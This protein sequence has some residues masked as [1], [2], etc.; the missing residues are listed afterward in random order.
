MLLQHRELCGKHCQMCFLSAL[1]WLPL[2]P[3]DLGIHFKSR[4]CSTLGMFANCSCKSLVI[5]KNV[6]LRLSPPL[7][8]YC[9][10]ID[11]TVGQMCLLLR[12]GLPDFHVEY[13]KP[14]RE[15]DLYRASSSWAFNTHSLKPYLCLFSQMKTESMFL[16]PR[17]GPDLPASEAWQE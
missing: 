13:F 4:F 3:M 1:N 6:F 5:G 10:K 12:Y 7:V 15:D 9:L 14:R 17:F 8:K 2:M 16:G 11:P